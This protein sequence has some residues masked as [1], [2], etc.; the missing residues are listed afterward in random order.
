MFPN[1]EYVL[2]AREFDFWK[3]DD[4]LAAPQDGNEHK[5]AR[6]FRS[7]LLPLAER[8]RFVKPGETVVPGIEALAAFGHTPGHLAFHVE[9]EGQR[10]LVW[11]DCAHHEV[12]SLAWPDWHALFD[13]DKSAGAAT[14]RTIYDMAATDRVL[15]ASYHTAFPSLGTVTRDGLGYRWNA[16]SG[17][18]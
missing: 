12:V 8:I 16:A 14:R 18:R 15:V 4:R 11:G 5:S 7:P 3:S 2:G 17:V 10:L 6:V 1:A 13:M 9:S